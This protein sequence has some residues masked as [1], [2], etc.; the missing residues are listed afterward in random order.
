M[1][2][3]LETKVAVEELLRLIWVNQAAGRVVRQAPPPP[4]V[5]CL[6]SHSSESEQNHNKENIEPALTI[7]TISTP[8]HTYGDTEKLVSSW[9]EEFTSETL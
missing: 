9:W 1:F 4:A 8:Y 2:A 6:L 7:V 5:Q 3:N